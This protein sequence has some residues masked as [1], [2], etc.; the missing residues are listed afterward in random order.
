MLTDD[1]HD[2]FLRPENEEDLQELIG[3]VTFYNG[4]NDPKSNT[5]LEDIKNCIKIFGYENVS[6]YHNDYMKYGDGIEEML[7]GFWVD[8]RNVNYDDEGYL[9]LTNA[10]ITFENGFLYI[11]NRHVSEVLRKYEEEKKVDNISKNGIKSKK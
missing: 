5:M 3:W 8:L 6:I 10:D 9:E 2:H 1:Y 4:E 7:S 11:Q